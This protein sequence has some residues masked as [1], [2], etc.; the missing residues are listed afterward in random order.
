[1]AATRQRLKSEERKLQIVDAAL[2]IISEHGVQGTT[3]TRIAE[4]VGVTHSALYA[5]FANRQE[6][7][8]AALDAVFQKIYAIHTASIVEDAV[9]RLREIMRYH[10]NALGPSEE[11]SYPLPLFEFIAASSDEGLAEALRAHEAEAT[12]Q[13]VAIIDEAK[14]QGRV[15]RS[16][17]SEQTAWM[18]AAC[19]WA[20]D[21]AYLM[22][23][24]MFHE[25]ALS[26]RMSDLILDS[27]LV[28]E[29]G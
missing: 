11:L 9:E 27:I 29:D 22:G 15:K 12:R 10:T 7:L 5:H 24:K 4:L 8:L 13:I 25:E 2:R 14:G 21:T 16:V 3:T 23:I 19:A 28:E 6:I 26:S 17:S 20:E 1:V 18:L